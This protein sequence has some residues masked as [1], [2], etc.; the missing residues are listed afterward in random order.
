MKQFAKDVQAI[1]EQRGNEQ[2]AEECVTQLQHALQ[3]G[4]LAEREGQDEALVV[5]SFLHDIGH[6]IEVDG[7]L[8][9][10]CTEDLH[11]FHE[12]KSYPWLRD[13]LGERIAQS[14]RLHVAAKRY[15]CTTNESYLNL[16][17][18]TSV[19]SFY[20]Q[21]GMMS[22]EE[23]ATFQANEFFEEAVALRLLD[24]K[25]KDEQAQTPPLAY[26]LEKIDRLSR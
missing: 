18:K 7:T 2:Y 24:D 4:T 13:N 14:V 10:G 19:K 9:E 6:I 3:C 5:A 8:P 22:A 23:I 16:L 12:E 15:L 20:D 21:G 17:S 1:F 26:F 11:D 25:A